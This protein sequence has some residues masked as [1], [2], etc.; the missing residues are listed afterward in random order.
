MEFPILN[1]LPCDAGSCI[2]SWA[3]LC[4]MASR[5]ARCSV[6]LLSYAGHPMYLCHS[7]A[8]AL[9]CFF[10]GLQQRLSPFGWVP[11]PLMSPEPQGRGS[12]ACRSWR[13]AWRGLTRGARRGITPCA[14]AGVRPRWTLPAGHQRWEG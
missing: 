10:Y 5:A 11:S 4:S 6:G 13:R 1:P 12:S 2:F 7:F 3:L 9:L 14:R 8:A